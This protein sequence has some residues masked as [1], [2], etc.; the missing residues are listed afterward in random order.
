GR[1]AGRGGL[2]PHGFTEERVEKLLAFIGWF[3]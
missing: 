1:P 2:G 3:N